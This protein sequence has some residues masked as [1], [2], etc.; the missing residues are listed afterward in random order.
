MMLKFLFS[1]AMMRACHCSTRQHRF[2]QLSDGI[3][4]KIR[5]QY[6]ILF[7]GCLEVD[8]ELRFIKA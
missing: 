7:F 5:S 3:L 8:D 2:P 6:M 4:L 1:V